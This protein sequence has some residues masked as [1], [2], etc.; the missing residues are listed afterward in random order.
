MGMLFASDAAPSHYRVM[1]ATPAVR[2]AIRFDSDVGSVNRRDLQASG[3]VQCG[4]PNPNDPMWFTQNGCS[5]S[6]RDNYH[7]LD[8]NKVRVGQKGELIK[9]TCD[10]VF[11]P[12]PQIP[13][14]Y[15]LDN[16]CSK[17]EF[18]WINQHEKW[19]PWVSEFPLI[20]DCLIY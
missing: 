5:I 7:Y 17:K 9:Q 4:T 8:G 2:A 15:E 20:D 10:D 14:C 11:C 6:S 18:C 16:A 19:G 12:I 1:H 3:E 13:D